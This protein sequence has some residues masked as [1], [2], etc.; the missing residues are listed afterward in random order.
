MSSNGTSGSMRG[1]RTLIVALTMILGLQ[2]AMLIPN[3]SLF[4]HDALHLS[5]AQLSLFLVAFHLS[6]LVSSLCMPALGDRVRDRTL[7]LPLSAVVAVVGYT[8][9]A[10]V[11]SFGAVL[12][13]TA[14]LVGPANC[15]NSLFFSYLRSVDGDSTSA[16]ATR[17]IFS[18]AWV[19]GPMLGAMVVSRYGFRPLFGSLVALNVMVL[20]G[21]I[22]LARAP[23]WSAQA[24]NVPTV[25]GSYIGAV[26]LVLVLLHGSNVIAT[27]IMP[28]VVTNE[29]GMRPEL[30]GFTFAICAV[31]EV[32]MFYLIS[33]AL[34]RYK[35]TTLIMAGCGFGVLYYLALG[36]LDD[37]RVLFA[38]QVLNAVFIAIAVGG[39]MAWF[40]DLMPKRPGLA[41]GI[42]MNTFRIGTLVVSPIIGAV[43]AWSGR[44]QVAAFAAAG[45]TM[46]AGGIVL[47]LAAPFSA[48]AAGQ[49]MA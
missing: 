20:A 15:Q 8:G 21:S 6:G 47:L 31:A 11:S 35:K 16:V 26:F 13:V 14:L 34:G 1:Q 7:L 25:S 32:V 23:R 18:A 48:R 22:G 9:Y 38:A 28:I 40:Q 27:T 39:G 5:P 44:Y 3:I 10:L 29:L 17:G 43:A 37:W 36:L 33:K 24:E 49:R 2:Q 30:V 4:A 42:F 45:V 12:W 19:V 46:V 41:T